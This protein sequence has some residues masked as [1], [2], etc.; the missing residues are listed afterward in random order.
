MKY[1]PESTYSLFID[2]IMMGKYQSLAEDIIK[3]GLDEAESMIFLEGFFTYLVKSGTYH[4]RQNVFSYMLHGM[5]QVE[6]LKEEHILL[7]KEQVD[8]IDYFESNIENENVH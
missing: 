8:M 2:Y 4:A 1:H 7:S 5:A 3:M 6:D